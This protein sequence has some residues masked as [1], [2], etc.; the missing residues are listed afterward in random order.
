[1]AGAPGRVIVTGAGGFLG[2][3]VLAALAAGGWPCEGWVRDAPGGPC[4][5]TLRAMGDLASVSEGGL[6][7]ALGGATAVVHC[8]GRAHVRQ[9]DAAGAAAL[10]RDNVVAT[11][12]LA[13]AARAAGLQRFVHISTVKVNG[14]RSPRGRPF[15]AADPAAPTDEYAR[16]KWGGEQALAAALGGSGTHACVLRIPLVYGPGASANFA[17]LVAAVAAHRRLPLAAIANRRHLLGLSNLAG[18]IR[19]ALAAPHP[20]AG[21]YFTADSNAV[22]T[23]ELVAAIAGALGIEARMV[24]VPVP[25]LRAV[26]RIAGYSASL[27]RLTDSFEVDTRPFSAATG[28]SPAPFGLTDVDVVPGPDE[29]GRGRGP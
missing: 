22:S 7:A 19:A 14:E 4:A 21:T 20:I 6:A 8:A 10:L 29:P 9:G 1:M 2:R 12:R 15:A 18:A 17:A 16:S 23:P 24:R 25:L 28:W 11:A 26:G 3:A 13:H 5:A 27:A